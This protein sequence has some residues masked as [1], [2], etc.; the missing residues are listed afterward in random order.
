VL[1]LAAD[2]SSDKKIASDLRLSPYTVQA[3]LRHIYEKL[4]VSSRTGACMRA[5]KEGLLELR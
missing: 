4:E 3:H 5:V 2:G 1:Q